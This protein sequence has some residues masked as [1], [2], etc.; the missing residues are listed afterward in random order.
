MIFLT[1]IH[2]IYLEKTN[3]LMNI[4]FADRH[5]KNINEKR[6]AGS[7]NDAG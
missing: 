3:S 1:L 7:Q 4:R 2:I 6:H 5:F